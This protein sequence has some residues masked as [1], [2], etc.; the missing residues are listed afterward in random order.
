VK[1]YSAALQV[2]WSAEDLNEPVRE[3]HR[4]VD[5]FLATV[6]QG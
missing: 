5:G 3:L 1:S 6:R 2:T 4:N